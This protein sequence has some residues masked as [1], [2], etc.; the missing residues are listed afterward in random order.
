MYIDEIGQSV[1]NK[2]MNDVNNLAVKR[3]W[4]DL[5]SAI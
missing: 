2:K 5:R 4:I 1:Y 3:R